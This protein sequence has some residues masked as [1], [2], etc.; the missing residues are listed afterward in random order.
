MT[1]PPAPSSDAPS[2][3]DRAW[4]ELAA[5]D[6]ILVCA[7][8]SAERARGHLEAAREAALADGID[9]PALPADADR[10]ALIAAARELAERI[11]AERR[12]RL[13][14]ALVGL[15]RRR[16]L[17][18][19]AVFLAWSSP[20]LAYAVLRP[21]TWREGPWRGAFYPAKNFEGE[22]KVRRYSDVAF[23]WK[24]AAPFKTFPED[25][26]SARFDT[27]V[28]LDEEVEP[29]FRLSSDDGSRLFV[30]GLLVVDNWGSHPLRVRSGSIALEPGV[31]HL[32]VEYFEH[33]GPAE[34]ELDASF[35]GDRP[36]AI[37][38]RI[39]RYPGDEP[40]P[41]APCAEVAAASAD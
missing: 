1:D 26:F 37:P 29:V 33:T 35:D 4:D 27:C 41:E 17:R 40:D 16:V 32:R 14:P 3:L 5:A 36:R 6:A 9:V 34:V 38:A 12:R 39:L 21:F 28:V 20:I 13:G 2:S 25:G 10:R 11:E 18:R 31:H 8:A 23:K 19:I 24:E 15:R 22:P 7:T 30:D